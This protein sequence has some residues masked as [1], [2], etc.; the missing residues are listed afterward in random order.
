MDLG[1]R[2]KV[3]VVMGGGGAI[4]G[5]IA[6]GL[7]RE[8]ANVAIWDISLTAAESKARE[9]SGQVQAGE[10]ARNDERDTSSPIVIAV[11]CDALDAGS[12][13]KAATLTLESF[14]TIDLLVNG[15]GGSR[16]EATTSP[17]LGFFDMPL[18]AIESVMGLNFMSAVVPC[19]EIGRIFA[20]KGSG[21][22]VNI[23][24]VAGLRPLT[25]SIAYCSGKAALNSF[26]RWLAVHMAQNYSH[27]I[28][29]NAVAPG[30]VLTEQNR[31]LLED[32][33]TK[34]L[35]ERGNAIIA[36]VPMGRLGRPDEITGAVLW[37]LSEA[38][39]FVTGAVVPVDGGF[40]SNS[41]V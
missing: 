29:V 30:F 31:F 17:E 12:V 21:A 13:R 41:G 25:R 34:G 6:R 39:S 40:S 11:E 1:L 15:A 5:E 2:G 14:G 16:K 7:A 19:R 4:C 36:H 10:A 28:R 38:A 9:I 27:A 33:L 3:A 20:Q 8:G 23:S 24:S 22:I 37:L 18:S 35:T 32:P 26:T